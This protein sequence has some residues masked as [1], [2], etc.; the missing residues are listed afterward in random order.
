[1]EKQIRDQQLNSL[2]QKLSLEKA[3]EG[4]SGRIM[5]EIRL[6]PIPQIVAK[7]NTFKII[8]W[9]V[10]VVMAVCLIAAVLNTP[11]DDGWKLPELGSLNFNFDFRTLNIAESLR[12]FSLP[13]LIMNKWV[14]FLGVGLVAFW[15]FFLLNHFLSRFFEHETQLTE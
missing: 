4:L 11:F 10:G 12:N 15:G 1:M 5:E 14:V 8:A 6:K 7:R 2:L 9:S 3:P 13:Q